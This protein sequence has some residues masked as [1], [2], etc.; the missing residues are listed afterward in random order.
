MTKAAKTEKTISYALM[1]RPKDSAVPWSAWAFL[2]SDGFKSLE[3][4]RKALKESEKLAD[5]YII[6][7]V[8]VETMK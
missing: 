4:V 3:D 6:V 7:R 5:N 2:W 1:E 8:V